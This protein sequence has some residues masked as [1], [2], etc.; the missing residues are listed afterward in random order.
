MTACK[1]PYAGSPIVTAGVEI[2]QIP[3]LILDLSVYYRF[4]EVIA[5]PQNLMPATLFLA[6]EKMSES[7]L[8]VHREKKIRLL[9]AGALV[10]TCGVLLCGICAANSHVVLY[11]AVTLLAHAIR[12]TYSSGLAARTM[13]RGR[14]ITAETGIRVVHSRDD[15]AFCWSV[16]RVRER[17]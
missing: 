12:I 13:S 1:A 2:G 8:C 5:L 6:S 16:G 15:V 4:V 11:T 9:T 17:R 10:Q 3:C 14:I 7:V